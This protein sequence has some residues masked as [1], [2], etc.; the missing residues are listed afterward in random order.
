MIHEYSHACVAQNL[1][2]KLD[3]ISLMPYGAGLNLKDQ[4]YSEIDEIKIAIAGPICNLVLFVLTLA[5]WWIFPESYSYLFTFANANLVLFLFNL[6]PAYPLDGGRV[7]CGIISSKYKR[8]IAIKI[9]SIFNIILSIILFV[10]FVVSIFYEVNFTLLFAT[11]FMILGISEKGQ[12]G[13][14]QTIDVLS[15]FSKQKKVV[16]VCSIAVTLDTKL[17]DIVRRL[18]NN[19]YNLV[20]VI[21]PNGKVKTLSQNQLAKIFMNSSLNQTLGEILKICT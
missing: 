12:S 19:K 15:V 8:K 17:I 3:S 18:K 7:L 2:Y 21:L 5:I 9:V 11:I 4:I 16:A 13:K 10:F 1:G 20:Y 14:Y 6:L